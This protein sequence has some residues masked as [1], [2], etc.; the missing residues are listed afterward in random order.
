MV[1]EPLKVLRNA[2][3]CPV[4]LMPRPVPKVRTR[5]KPVIPRV[6]PGVAL[7]ML[8]AALSRVAEV[9]K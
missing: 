2:A 5:L 1:S 4:W 9:R 7:P 3:K 6:S 8:I